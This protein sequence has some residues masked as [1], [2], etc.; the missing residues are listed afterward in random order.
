MHTFMGEGNMKKLKGEDA[1]DDS[2]IK[3][4]DYLPVD[5]IDE[6]NQELSDQESP[7]IV[8]RKRDFLQSQPSNDAPFNIRIKSTTKS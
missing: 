5:V 8:F 7:G 2:P 4:G 6:S 3:V 1:L